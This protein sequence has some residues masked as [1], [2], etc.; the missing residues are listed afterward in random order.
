[1]FSQPQIRFLLDR[2]VLVRLYTRGVP[3]GVVQSPDAAGATA[4]RDSF[5]TNAL[6]YYPVLR[7]KGDSY[8]FLDSYGKEDA[9]IRDANDFA[10]FLQKWLDENKAK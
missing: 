3:A 4:L 6:P 10:N 8:E 7:P 2:Y 5:G 1:V 9:L